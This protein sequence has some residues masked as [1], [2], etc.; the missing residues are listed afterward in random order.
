MTSLR[1]TKMA[2]RDYILID[3]NGTLIFFMVYIWLW[4][5]T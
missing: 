5:N 4:W 1:N 2:A 3:I